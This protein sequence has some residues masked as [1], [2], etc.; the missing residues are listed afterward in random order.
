MY[1]RRLKGKS[2]KQKGYETGRKRICSLG[3]GAQKHDI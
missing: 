2:I 1:L 3:Q